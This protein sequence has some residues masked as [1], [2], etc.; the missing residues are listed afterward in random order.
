MAQLKWIHAACRR[1]LWMGQPQVT[2]QAC[3][4]MCTAPRRATSKSLLHAE[5]NSKQTPAANGA[6]KSPAKEAVEVQPFEVDSTQAQNVEL[7]GAPAERPTSVEAR[8]GGRND[9]EPLFDGDHIDSAT[10]D[11]QILQRSVSVG[12]DDDRVFCY[13]S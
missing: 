8:A 4:M 12:L 9:R 1:W 5:E 6:G 7:A 10:G 11:P 13:C 2:K 3:V